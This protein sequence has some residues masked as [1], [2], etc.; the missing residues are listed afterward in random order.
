MTDLVDPTLFAPTPE[1]VQALLVAR[2]DF[3]AT[4]TPTYDEVTQRGLDIAAELAGELTVLPA[5]LYGLATSTVIYKVAADIEAGTWPEQQFGNAAAGA[6]WYARYVQAH[7]RLIALAQS[8]G[9]APPRG[10][11]V[12]APSQ[13][14]LAARDIIA[15][16]PTA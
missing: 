15:T 13:T 2:G 6:I 7:D 5:Q 9:D 11:S 12:P 3:T 8:Y 1:Q 14:A 10:G 4:S 16:L